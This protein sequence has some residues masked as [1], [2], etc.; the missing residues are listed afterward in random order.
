MGINYEI[1]RQFVNLIIDKFRVGIA[2]LI[3][4]ISDLKLVLLN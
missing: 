3:R 2:V 1:G 4:V